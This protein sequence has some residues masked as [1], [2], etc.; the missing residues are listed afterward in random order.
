MLHFIRC[1][2]YACFYFRIINNLIRNLCTAVGM[3]MSMSGFSLALNTYFT[4]RRGR[5]MGLAMTLTALGPILM[6]QVASILLSIYGTGVIIK[7]KL[8]QCICSF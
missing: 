3:S 7:K 6:P 4:M 1:F 5:A 8:L 2:K